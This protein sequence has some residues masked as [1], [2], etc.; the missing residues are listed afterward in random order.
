MFQNQSSYEMKDFSSRNFY[1]NAL[2]Q[3]MKPLAILV[4]VRVVTAE[5]PASIMS[6]AMPA[7]QS[8][9]R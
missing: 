7:A 8:A 5:Q 6:V 2:A 3:T 4:Q 1:S 9:H